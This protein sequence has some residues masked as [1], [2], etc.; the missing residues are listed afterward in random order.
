M[1]ADGSFNNHYTLEVQEEAL[2]AICL[3]GKQDNIKLGTNHVSLRPKA[4]FGNISPWTL[5][6]F[7]NSFD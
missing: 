1:S 4:N 7:L 5:K 3:G 2:Q 6:V